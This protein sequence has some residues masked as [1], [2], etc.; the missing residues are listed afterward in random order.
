MKNKSVPAPAVTPHK[1]TEQEF[2]ERYQALCKEMG[3]AIAFAPNWAQSKDTGDYR[4]VITSSIV[5]LPKE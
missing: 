2:A 3:F 5:P 4:L 1:Y